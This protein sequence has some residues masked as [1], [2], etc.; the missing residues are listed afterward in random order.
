MRPFFEPGVVAVVGASRER[1]KIGSEILNNLVTAGF[2]G[3]IVP[4]HPIALEIGGLTAYPRVSD[5]PG[6][7]DLAM[8]VVPA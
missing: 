8:I 2:T 7:V 4:V 3:A 5:I 6:A 1:G